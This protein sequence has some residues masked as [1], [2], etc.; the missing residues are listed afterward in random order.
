MKQRFHENYKKL[1]SF[2][3]MDSTLLFLLSTL[4]PRSRASY[5]PMRVDCTPPVM[6]P[7]QP[8]AQSMPPQQCLDN[9]Q[10]LQQQPPQPQQQPTAPAQQ[11]TPSAPPQNENPS[12]PSA[13][14]NNTQ[15]PPTP[16]QPN[17]CTPQGGAN[18]NIPQNASPCSPPPYNPYANQGP[19]N[20]MPQVYQPQPCEQQTVPSNVMVS[21]PTPHGPQVPGSN[22]G[23][24]QPLDVTINPMQNNGPIKQPLSNIITNAVMGSAPCN[25][26]PQT[27]PVVTVGDQQY[28]TRC[29]A[30]IAPSSC[31]LEM[32]KQ[33]NQCIA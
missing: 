18:N 29:D 32:A 31:A 1:A 22:C 30:L 8:A 17:S 24:T 20:V 33:A 7:Y 12:S 2:L 13:P 16:E 9:S 10:Q 4:M 27:V 6:I 21:A 14:A 3:H 28:I 5:A 19:A 11:Q 25:G 26:T 23:T 15:Q